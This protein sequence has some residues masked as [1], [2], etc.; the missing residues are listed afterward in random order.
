[1]DALKESYLGAL[2]RIEAKFQRAGRLDEVLLTKDEAKDISE[3]KWPLAA[4]PEKISLDVA[5]PRKIYLKKHIEIEQ[6]AARKSADTAD[7][8]LALLDQQAVSLTKSGDLQQAL[9]ARQIKA[10][11]ESDATLVSARKLLANVRSD[12]TSRP[13]L[14]IRRYGDN[15]EVIVRYDMRGKV[16]MDSPVSN[17]KEADKSIGDTTAKVLGEFVGAEGYVVDSYVHFERDFADSDFS[18]I[19]LSAIGHQFSKQYGDFTALEFKILPNG[20]NPYVTL[21]VKMIPISIGGTT[22]IS[23]RHFTPKTNRTVNGFKLIQGTAGGSAFGGKAFESAGEWITQT[24]ISEPTS[25]QGSLLLYF[26]FAPDNKGA[27]LTQEPIVIG[28][29]K[30]EHVKFSAF[31][32]Q[33]LGDNGVITESF[34]EAEKQPKI[35]S[36]GELLPQP[37]R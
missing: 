3:G 31:L 21:P 9:L 18:G 12:G 22:Q 27:D 20:V 13:A 15:I 11:I 23:I 14:K 32:V 36:N 16:S 2:A 17:V 37:E 10:E 5:A 1:M 4:L 25:E 7:K 30:V 35:I 6:E 34:E 26:T 29:I 19:A 33:R 8:M 24:V 28:H